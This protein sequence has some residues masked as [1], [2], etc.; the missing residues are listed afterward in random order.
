[1][2]QR[3]LGWD[4]AGRL[5]FAGPDGEHA[6]NA[7]A[8]VLALGGASWARLG[9]DGAWVPLLEGRRVAVAPLRAA[10]CGFDVAWSPHFIE[11]NA[12][13]PVKSVRGIVIDAQGIEH[14]AQGECMISSYGIEGG[15][16]YAL[17]STLRD[18]LDATGAATLHLDLAPARDEAKLAAALARPRGSRSMANHLRAVAGIE[19]VKAGLL[20]E[21]LAPDALGNAQR[22]ART[23]KRLPIARGRAAAHRR[24]DQHRGRRAVRGARRTPDAARRA[25]RVLRRR[26]ARLGGAD[27]RLSAHRVLRQRPRG[28]RRRGGVARAGIGA[29]CS[30]S[31]PSAAIDSRRPPA[32]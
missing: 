13:K 11:R 30:R 10:N 26:D 24:S 3:W 18:T 2:R 6:V 7:D 17:S 22:V 27:R 29:Q 20:R 4:D 15:L 21:V 1:M 32:R 12:G 5:R 25:R 31:V 28:G 19:G 8:T 9:S 16:V 14:W 23:I